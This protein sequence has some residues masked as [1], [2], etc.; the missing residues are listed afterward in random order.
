MAPQPQDVL[1]ADHALV[2]RIAAADERALGELYDRYGRMAFSLAAAMLPDAADAEEVVAD[3]FA[4]IWR[5]AANFDPGRGSVIG[6]VATIVRT[7]TLDL[8]RSQRRRSRAI[9]RAT[10]MSE[11]GAAPMLSH[12]EMAD[13]AAERNDAR[14]LVERSLVELPPPQRTV[15]E[16]AYFGG[17]SQSEIA[18]RLSEPL[19]TIKTRMR[20]GMEKMRAALR[21]LM[22]EAR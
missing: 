13:R 21:P 17:L 18:E 19:G 5:S 9:E 11:D 12:A 22:E 2:A 4:Q 6:W 10:A 14:V 1:V 16:L 20:A 3:A 15:I 8:L 7:R